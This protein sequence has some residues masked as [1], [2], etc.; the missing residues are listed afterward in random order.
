MKNILTILI[1]SLLSAGTMAITALPWWSYIVLI[2]IAGA[3]LPLRKWQVNP[4]LAGALSGGITWLT[5]SLLFEAGAS[6]STIGTVA[7]I[8]DV[9]YITML[10]IIAG[11]AAMTNGLALF[12]GY[13]LR[14]GKEKLE[15]KIEA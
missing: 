14:N 10:L 15:L 12:A 5:L 11:V 13:A 3:A 8:F 2:F 4:L 1:L 6:A 9:S 7:A